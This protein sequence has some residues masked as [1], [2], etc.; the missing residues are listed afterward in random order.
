MMTTRA[1]SPSL[2]HLGGFAWRKYLERW[3]FQPISRPDLLS[4]EPR[5]RN[6]NLLWHLL[7]LPRP[8]H[9]YIRWNLYRWFHH[10]SDEQYGQY[11]PQHLLQLVLTR[12]WSVVH[13]L[14]DT[15]RFYKDSIHYPIHTS[16]RVRF[17]KEGWSY[18]RSNSWRSF[19]DRTNQFHYIAKVLSHS[20]IFWCDVAEFLCELHRQRQPSYQRQI[21]SKSPSCRLHQFHLRHL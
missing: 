20:Y 9:G 3:K 18:F 8:S 17:R 6:S 4:L 7:D 2:F 15:D 1:L 21:G 5:L 19:L 14:T 16:E 11:P 13:R 12:T 10:S